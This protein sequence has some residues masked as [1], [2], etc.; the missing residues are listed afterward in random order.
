MLTAA[1]ADAVGPAT[2]ATGRAA[3]GGGATAKAGEE[4]RTRG[5]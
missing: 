5:L 4:G 1:T 3:A 2:A